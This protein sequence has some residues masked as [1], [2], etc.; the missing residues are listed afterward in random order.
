MLLSEL[1]PGSCVRIAAWCSY[2]APGFPS[3]LPSP[4][5]TGPCLK[6]LPRFPVALLGAGSKAALPTRVKAAAGYMQGLNTWGCQKQCGGGTAGWD[7]RECQQ[8]LKLAWPDSHCAERSQLFLRGLCWRE[9][10]RSKQRENQGHPP[11]TGDWMEHDGIPSH[12]G[13]GLCL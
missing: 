10:M 5:P 13:T 3:C 4:V 1:G 12:L 9:G 11:H 2:S 7:H 8:E 6:P